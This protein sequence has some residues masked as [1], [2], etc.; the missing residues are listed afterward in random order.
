V[1]AEVPD[2]ALPAACSEVPTAS[3][4][5]AGLIAEQD[6]SLIAEARA[7]LARLEQLAPEVAWIFGQFHRYAE[8]L[9]DALELELGDTTDTAWDLA[10]EAVGLSAL[11]R[12][13]DLII[14]HHPE[15]NQPARPKE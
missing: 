15:F 1:T 3:E 11:W 6:A 2:F 4:V 9:G 5:M 7:D 14:D 12:L 13:A 8:R 10:A